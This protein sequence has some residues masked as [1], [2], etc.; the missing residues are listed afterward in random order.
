MVLFSARNIPSPRRIFDAVSLIAFC[1][2]CPLFAPTLDAIAHALRP[3]EPF[4]SYAVHACALAGPL[5]LSAMAAALAFLLVCL[6][7]PAIDP[8]RRKACALAGAGYGAGYAAAA[9]CMAGLVHSPVVEA[10]AGVVLGASSA[11]VA[12]AWM[13]RMGAK[14]LFSS[15]R[16]VWACAAFVFVSD[17]A[18]A[19]LDFRVLAFV[20]AAAAAIVAAGMAAFARDGG[21]SAG[22]AREGANWL[23]VFGRLDMSA[24][25]GADDFHTPGAC[26]LFFVGVPLAMTVLFA[27]DR[28]VADMLSAPA[29]L[30]VAGG[31]AALVGLLALARF[32][33]DRALVNASYRFFLPA[34]AFASFAAA[35]F[36]QGAVQHAVLATGGFAFLSIYALMMA[37]VLTAMAGRMASLALPSA[38]L[39]VAA[40]SLA[41]LIGSLPAGESVIASA[42]YPVF[43]SSFIAAAA[44]LVATPGSRLWRVVLDGVDAATAG[45]PDAAEA[46]DAACER[47]SADFALTPREKEALVL[48]GRGH[49][50]AFVAEQLVIAESTARS[51]RKN[52][53]RKLG[54]KSREELF[55]LIDEHEDR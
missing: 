55:S 22:R 54:V 24:I 26:G 50:S 37:G 47:L 32:G 39:M 40:A 3:D 46:Y 8:I 10:V 11:V 16:A 6:I 45:A 44:L 36:A 15:F 17:F 20:L 2:S 49:T 53:Y 35:A 1:A 28:G 34:V 9:A 5:A 42:V 52:I 4:G 41:C 25:D 30:M 18:Y 38:S 43:L 7:E 21:A 23:E 51:H 33:T 14:S 19:L 13:E 31:L 29:P 48:L 12:M 27:A